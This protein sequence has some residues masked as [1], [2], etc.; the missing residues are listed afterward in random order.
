MTTSAVIW[1]MDGVIADTARYHFS[2]WQELA[3]ENG[4]P[5]TEEDF[6][7]GFGR[8]N[9]EILREFLGKQPSSDEIQTLS[10]RKEELFRRLIDGRVVAFPGA[11]ALLRAL[12]LLS[13]VKQAL[14]TSTPIENVDLILGTLRI[15]GCFE[16]VVA[17]KDV[18][19]GKPD[20][21]AFLLAAERLKVPPA[22]C[23]V[24]EDAV[25]GVKAARSANM[26][27]IAVTNTH[28]GER[29]GE[30]DLVVDSLAK[31]SVETI[32]NLLRQGGRQW[33]R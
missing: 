1:D 32:R 6:R 3:R 20:P 2:S 13:R 19:R 26:K 14:A 16:S 4:V 15:A 31:V 18:A 24:I 10:K 9:P 5:F 17:D 29:L 28:P 21:Q 11:L 23:V 33:T 27:C 30:A 25:D 22:S 8:R 12:S 7:R